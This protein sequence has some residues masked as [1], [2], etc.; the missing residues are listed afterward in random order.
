MCALSESK[1][2][3]FHAVF[4]RNWAKT[5]LAAPLLCS[6][7][8]LLWKILDLLLNTSH[9]SSCYLS[10][11]SKITC[12]NI[13]HVVNCKSSLNFF[14]WMDFGVRRGE[15]FGNLELKRYYLHPLD[16]HC[17]K[18]VD[19]TQ[20]DVLPVKRRPINDDLSWNSTLSGRY[21]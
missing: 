18:T 13:F 4:G 17:S 1:C 12:R 7:R 15:C 10:N 3:H 8:P 5:R 21:I 6:W 11:Q 20:S 2:S 14:Q 16:S 9:N 19:N